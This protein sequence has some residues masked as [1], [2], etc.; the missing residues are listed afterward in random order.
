MSS[1]IHDCL[2]KFWQIEECPGQ[3]CFTTD[4]MK[5]ED[6]FVANMKRSEAGRFIV[7]LPKRANCGNLGESLEQATNR[8][9]ALERK[10]DL[11]EIKRSTCLVT[12]VVDDTIINRFSSFVKL[13]RVV[14]YCLR[15]KLNT[16]IRKKNKLSGNLNIEE[17]KNATLVLFRGYLQ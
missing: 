10:F 5:C 2:E 3:R 15:F 6:D 12:N 4:E 17:L 11:P 7:S 1:N 9:L 16:T 13:Q 14:A 8:F